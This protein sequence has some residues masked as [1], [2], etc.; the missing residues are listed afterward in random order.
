MLI[1]EGTRTASA[2]A[3]EFT[4]VLSI[5]ADPKDFIHKVGD[6][7]ATIRLMQ[8]LVRL[9]ASRLRDQTKAFSDELRKRNRV[10]RMD[11]PGQKQTLEKIKKTLPE[12]GLIRRVVR[13]QTLGAGEV[14]FRQGEQADGFYFIHEGTL[15]VCKETGED[16]PLLTIARMEAPTIVGEMGFFRGRKS[17]GN[18]PRRDGH[19]LHTLFRHRFR[20]TQKEFR[21]RPGRGP[22]RRVTASSAPHSRQR[23]GLMPAAKYLYHGSA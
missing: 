6:I 18:A 8:N 1:E 13:E 23:A 5:D 9:L 12:R 2:R 20:K 15:E 4:E 7:D 21:R 16:K 14:P 3:L 17:R 19:H 22:A 10:L 11:R